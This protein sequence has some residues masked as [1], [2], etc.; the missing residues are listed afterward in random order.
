M[1]GRADWSPF[2]S[3]W[4]LDGGLRSFREELAHAGRSIAALKLLAVVAIAASSARFRAP[5]DGLAAQ[6]SHNEI[7]KLAGLSRPLIVAAKKF[8]AGQGVFDVVQDSPCG[9]TVY[10]LN[11]RSYA[12]GS[13]HHTAA[14]F[15][16]STSGIAGLRGLSCRQT[17]G[18]RAMKAYMLLSGLRRDDAQSVVTSRA[19][20]AHLTG[21]RDSQ[22]IGALEEL[23]KRRMIAADLRAVRAGAD[24]GRLTLQTCPL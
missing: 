1:G 11:A 9:R 22:V 7:S 17:S 4:I 18:L 20:I 10:R 8:L 12:Y 5:G 2:P 6:I 19:E 16:G 21:L 24:M 14:I 15:H 13:I 23:R 3:Q